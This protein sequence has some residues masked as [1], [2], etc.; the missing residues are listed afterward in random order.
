MKVPFAR[1]MIG[2]A[3]RD[4][5]LETL[6]H[7]QLTNAGQVRAFE[8]RFQET[9]G[10]GRAVA[11]SSC[12]AALHLAFRLTQTERPQ[13]IMP[14]LNHR[15][16]AHAAELEGLQCGFVDVS[17]ETG[18]IDPAVIAGVVTERTSTIG[19]VHLL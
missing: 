13:V 6:K 11:V 5:V 14:A 17:P 19:L 9:V 4:A 12:M 10:G 2:K 1:P 18:N 15:A 8:E 7:P 16:M 3:E